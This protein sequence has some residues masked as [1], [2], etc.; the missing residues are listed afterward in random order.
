MPDPSPEAGESSCW[1]ASVGSRTRAM[2]APGVELGAGAPKELT[3]IAKSCWLR[4]QCTKVFSMWSKAA[5]CCFLLKMK[6]CT[7]STNKITLAG[8]SC[9]LN[10]NTTQQHGILP[11]LGRASAIFMGM[12]YIFLS[13]FADV[14][15]FC[16]KRLKNKKENAWT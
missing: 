16:N 2:L 9:N 11:T 4:S 3:V 5:M 7:C 13:T 10:E 1:A 12:D 8:Q 6:F 14:V 15:S